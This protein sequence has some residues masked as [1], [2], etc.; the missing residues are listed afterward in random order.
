MPAVSGSS[1]SLGSGLG[2]AQAMLSHQ[3][4]EA[5]SRLSKAR[6]PMAGGCASSTAG[7]LVGCP[8]P[9]VVRTD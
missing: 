2:T 3:R 8:A 5:S 7:G 6:A 9:A 4:S 1:L